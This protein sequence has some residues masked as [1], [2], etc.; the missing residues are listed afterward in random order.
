MGLRVVVGLCD[1]S[2]V[3]VAKSQSNLKTM[4][5]AVM[6]TTSGTWGCAQVCERFR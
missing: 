1:P 3:K 5:E 4:Y 2:L 6:P